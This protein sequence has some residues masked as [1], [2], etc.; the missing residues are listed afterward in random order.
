MLLGKS[1]MQP[2]CIGKADFHAQRF[3]WPELVQNVF[4][5][6]RRVVKR[7]CV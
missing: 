7:D 3:R 6:N 4:Q 2:L 5:T 1:A